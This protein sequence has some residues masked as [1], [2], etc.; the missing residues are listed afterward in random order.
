MRRVVT[1]RTQTSITVSDVADVDPDYKPPRYTNID[2]PPDNGCAACK[3]LD[4]QR[5]FCDSCREAWKR[6]QTSG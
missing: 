5:A 1:V 6:G 3:A 2:P 4:N